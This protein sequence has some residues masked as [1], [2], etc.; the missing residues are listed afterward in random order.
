MPYETRLRGPIQALTEFGRAAGAGIGLPINVV[1]PLQGTSTESMVIPGT[2]RSGRKRVRSSS[3]SRRSRGSGRRRLN[4]G[5][6]RAPAIRTGFRRTNYFTTLGMRPGRYPSKKHLI[7]NQNAALLDKVQ[8]VERLVS[9][10]YSDSERM[11]ARQGRL[12]NVRG[13]KFRCWWQLKNQS[14]I[15][16]K[17]DVP[18]MVRWAILLPKENTGENGDVGPTNFFIDPDPTTEEAVDFSSGVNC[19]GIQNRQINRRLY[20]V[21]QQGKFILAQDPG[22]NNSRLSIK[23]FKMVNLWLPLKRQ[24]KWANNVDEFPNTNIYFVCWYSKMGDKNTG[25]QFTDGPLEFHWESQT[26][27]KDSL[28]FN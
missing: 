9:V 23:A 19:F 2:L 21:M 6:T 5:P 10:P 22:S 11:N 13:V 17:L 16:D 1:T 3:S 8:Y 18:I 20:G 14:E 27:F 26:Y 7:Q 28:G 12:A 4:Y 15:S 24:M 25:S